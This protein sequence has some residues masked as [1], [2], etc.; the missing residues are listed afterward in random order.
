MRYFG[1]QFLDSLP[2]HR[3]M[4]FEIMHFKHYDEI[5]KLIPDTLDRFE[6]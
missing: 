4:L 3:H 6:G 1:K 2:A 5:E